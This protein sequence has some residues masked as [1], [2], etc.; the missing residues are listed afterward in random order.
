[1][2]RQQLGPRS[3]CQP[4]EGSRAAAHHGTAQATDRAPQAG[5]SSK[6]RATKV[7]GQPLHFTTGNTSMNTSSSA[8]IQVARLNVEAFLELSRIAL[9]SVQRTA[10]LNL[11][12]SRTTIE[13]SLTASRSVLL[14]GHVKDSQAALSELPASSRRNAQEYVRQLQA[15]ASDTQK[16]VA[17]LLTSY[18]LP[19]SD[20]A[21]PAAD[22]LKGLDLFKIFTQ[23]INT[24]TEASSKIVGDA[25]A[26]LKEAQSP[27]SK[28][29]S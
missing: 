21:N 27:K 1:L 17:H 13:E 20:G 12:A 2:E 28:S 22:W 5:A 6:P 7:Q 26:Q 8:P 24:M 23:Q 14:A 11:E 10:A 9:S 3:V 19:D 4:T 16:E 15:I 29:G 18:Q 25:T